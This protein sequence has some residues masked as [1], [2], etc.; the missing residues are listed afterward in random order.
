MKTHRDKL[1]KKL[2]LHLTHDPVS[3]PAHYTDGK[4]E[5]IHFIEDKKLG[6]HLGNTVKYI[7]RAGKKGEH[8]LIQ[9]LEKA[10]WYLNRHIQNLKKIKVAVLALFISL[11][12]LAQITLENNY[13]GYCQS[14]KISDTDYVYSVYKNREVYI[15]SSNHQLLADVELFGS[16]KA[17]AFGITLVSK[18]LFN[19]D[20]LLEIAYWYQDSL[21]Y[22]LHTAITTENGLELFN[23][24]GT[25]Y[26]IKAGSKSKMI[27]NATNGATEKA[28]VFSLPGQYISSYTG[29][30]ETESKTDE[31]P[32][33]NPA[34]DFVILPYN[35]LNNSGLLL[36]YSAN[37]QQMAKYTISNT[38][39]QLMV[40]T[41]S[42]PSGM[43]FYK[44]VSGNTISQSKQFIINN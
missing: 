27:L 25:V 37:G 24:T 44:T 36:I 16:V 23:D 33:P 29:K 32:F 17:G 8:Y 1:V 13:S 38:A 3:R 2:N 4:I 14:F 21:S 7:A 20:E 5:V 43:Y 6:F 28:K 42:M 12:G 19:T 10:A 40:N 35:I 22:T 39:T 30:N 15:Y 18:K 26:F 9:D 11:T 41:T 34:A 31:D